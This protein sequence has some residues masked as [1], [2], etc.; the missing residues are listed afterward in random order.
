M[1][2]DCVEIGNGPVKLLV[3]K[4]IGPRIL[5]LSYKGSSNLFAELPDDYLEFPGNGNF[6]F[7]G[8][9]RLWLA[10]EN[11]SITYAPDNQPISI[12]ETE[13]QIE[14]IQETIPSNGIRKSIRIEFSDFD[15][16]LII[17]HCIENTGSRAFKCAPWAITQFKLG[18]EAILPHQ[19]IHPEKINLLPDRSF[20]LW[21]YSDIND[22]RIQWGNPFIIISSHP[23]GAPLK[24][25]VSN[26][27]KWMAY[28]NE[29]LLFIKY[30]EFHETGMLADRGAAR[31]CYC[32][33]KF[34]ELE[35]L[36]P[37]VKIKPGKSVRHREVWRIVENSFGSLSRENMISFMEKDSLA[38]QCLGML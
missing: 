34:I 2:Q 30:A 9:H 36:G 37:L 26:S 31:E 10:P 14:L 13:G 24:I 12:R 7:F 21:P 17:D 4:S 18:G 16:V 6:N 25:G 11:P 33:S 22:P 28:F 15:N 20:I 3:S 5:S 8:G 32:N 23:R 19:K 29:A 38:K 1:G 35:T 27:E